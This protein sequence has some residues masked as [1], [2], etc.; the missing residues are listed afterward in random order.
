MGLPKD[1]I[2]YIPLKETLQTLLEDEIF[3]SV[4][5][6]E[7]NRTKNLDLNED[8]GEAF[9]SNIFFINNPDAYPLLFYS[10]AVKLVNPSG[11]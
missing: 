11:T 2:H 10:D 6:K 9:K 4:M 8:V 5:E 7:R 1:S 3:L